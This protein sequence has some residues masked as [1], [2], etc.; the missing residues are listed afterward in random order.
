[1]LGS[2]VILGQ[3]G[4]P[5]KPPRTMGLG[6][7]LI[8]LAVIPPTA[9]VAGSCRHVDLHNCFN[10]PA[11]LDFSSVPDISSRI[12]GDEPDNRPAQH[13]LV[14]QQPAAE[15]YTGPMIGVVNHVGAPEVGYYWSIH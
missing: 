14:E 6:A 11:T 7:I 9:S 4:L 13:P 8:A 3:A 5:M 15:P 1:M 2:E 10:L 12:V